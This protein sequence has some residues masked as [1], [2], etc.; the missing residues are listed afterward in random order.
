M[1]IFNPAAA[2]G[3]AATRLPEIR[4]L[5]TSHGIDF[6]I[7]LTE[8]PGH[9]AE[10]AERAC[11]ENPPGIVVAA[12]GEGTANEVINGFMHAKACSHDPPPLAVFCVG[13]G[14]DFAYEAGLPTD[15]GKAVESLS[16]G[17]AVPLDVGWL[18][19]GR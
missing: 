6:E 16:N 12:G 11:S 8:R 7:A 2:Q 5:L 14:N 18:R 3:R 17:A 9:A 4:R 13:R 15:L 19:G 1:I 10:L